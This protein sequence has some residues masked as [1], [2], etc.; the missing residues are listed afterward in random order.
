MNIDQTNY[1]HNFNYDTS[2]HRTVDFI[3]VD[4]SRTLRRSGSSVRA[5]VPGA[6]H[7]RPRDSW[8][9]LLEV[10]SG[11]QQWAQVS[12]KRSFDPRKRYR[13][14][15]P[16]LLRK[17]IA[18]LLLL[19]LRLLLLLLPILLRKSSALRT[20]AAKFLRESGPQNPRGIDAMVDLKQIG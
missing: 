12:V 14:S 6:G 5:W 3:D 20:L 9:G 1:T 4:L 2:H 15:T 8:G 18:R 17:F 7:W 10:W 19:L 11:G 13:K 16:Q